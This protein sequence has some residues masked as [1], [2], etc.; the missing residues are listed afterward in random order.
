M[1]Y[2]ISWLQLLIDRAAVSVMVD[3]LLT[4]ACNAASGTRTVVLTIYY[5]LLTVLLS[6]FFVRLK[7]AC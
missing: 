1:L 2:L 6:A 5:T 3:E 4:R 7:F